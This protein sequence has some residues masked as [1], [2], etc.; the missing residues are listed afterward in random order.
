M[1]AQSMVCFLPLVIHYPLASKN[2]G[3]EWHNAFDLGSTW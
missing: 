1:E 3:S 2:I